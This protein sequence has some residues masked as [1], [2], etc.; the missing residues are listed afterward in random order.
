MKGV[1]G[2]GAGKIRN[3]DAA[4]GAISIAEA[5]LIAGIQHDVGTFWPVNGLAK[6]HPPG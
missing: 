4:R 5:F 6:N 3:R 1:S 2:D